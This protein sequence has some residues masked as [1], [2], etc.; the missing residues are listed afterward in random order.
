MAGTYGRIGGESLPRRGRGVEG[1][2]FRLAAARATVD[3]N[4][5]NEKSKCPVEAT[6]I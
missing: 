3:G 6:A 5:R 1:T 4:G 2:S